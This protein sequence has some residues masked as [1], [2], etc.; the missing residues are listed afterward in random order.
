MIAS[1]RYALFGDITDNFV[2]SANGSETIFAVQNTA[3]V[4]SNDMAVYYA[5]TPYGR[6]D[7]QVLNSHLNNYEAGDQRATLF[8]QTGRG[9]MTT[10]YHSSDSSVDPRRTNITV[11][12]LA[13]M[14]LTRAEANIRTSGSVGDTPVNDINR[15]RTRVGLPAVAS[16][17][18]ADVLRE[19]RNELMFE[20]VL[21][22]DMKRTQT[23]TT[24]LT[25]T[26]PWND[27]SLVFPIPDRE[28]LVNAQ[29][30]QNPGY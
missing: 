21:F 17:T 28:M 10:K 3:T 22:M 23:P 24:G 14:Y 11:L 29:L 1:N 13:E 27:N 8:V 26:I 20:G 16:V 5:P 30:T 2:R 19:R 15:I 25:T 18:L 7:V 12:R 4:F 9:R 6:A